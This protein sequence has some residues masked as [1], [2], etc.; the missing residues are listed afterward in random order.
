MNK[1]IIKNKKKKQREVKA[2]GKSLPGSAGKKVQ[3][4]DA[5]GKVAC[6]V[7]PKR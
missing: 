2:K 4:E 1:K 6:K 5:T 7:D 3:L